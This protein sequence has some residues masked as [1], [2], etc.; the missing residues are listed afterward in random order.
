[1]SK[2]Y[3]QVVC[4][5]GHQRT[6]SFTWGTSPNGFCKECGDKLISKC[7]KCDF[8]IVGNYDPSGE[9]IVVLGLSTTSVPKYCQNCGNPYPW[10]ESAIKSAQDLISYSELSSD[11][12][13]DFQESIPDLLSDTPKTK[14]ASTKF[15]IYAAKAGTV[16]AQGLR[17]ILVD[18][19]SETVKKSIWGV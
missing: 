10:T 12:V 13:K 14:L 11:E 3:S 9:G 8:P 18:V 17:D 15:K 7:P 5:N 2:Q 4:L 1:M 6:A 19:A 16:V